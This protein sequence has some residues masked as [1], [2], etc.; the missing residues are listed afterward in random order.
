MHTN[1]Q[2]FMASHSWP[3][4]RRKVILPERNSYRSVEMQD[5]DHW[6]SDGPAFRTCLMIISPGY[7]C[8]HIEYPILLS[9]EYES[10]WPLVISFLS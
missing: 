8:S 2:D 9:R 1:S 6:L 3:R 10:I 4:D 5:T 7:S